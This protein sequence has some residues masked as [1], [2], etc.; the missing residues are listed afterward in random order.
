VD[1]NVSFKTSDGNVI[2]K[3]T[4]GQKYLPVTFAQKGE[5]A[6]IPTLALNLGA[7]WK[8]GTCYF[9]SGGGNPSGETETAAV[10]NPV[11]SSGG[12]SSEKSSGNTASA[13]NTSESTAKPCYV[14]N[15]QIVNRICHLNLK[16]VY[17]EY[18]ITTKMIQT[19]LNAEASSS[20]AVSSKA[21]SSDTGGQ[22]QKSGAPSGSSHK[23]SS[24]SDAK[25]STS[26]QGASIATKNANSSDINVPDA[27]GNNYDN[28]YGNGHP[29]PW[30]DPPQ[31]KSKN[32]GNVTCTIRCDTAVANWS[33]IRPSKRDNK[34]V[35][36]NG[37]IYSVHTLPI[38][39]NE[40]VYD[41][42]VSICKANNI[43]EEHTYTP[44]Y[45]AEYIKGINN[46]YEF[47]VGQLSGWMY[48]V[49]GWYPNYG[50]SRYVLQ[51]G[52]GVQWNYTCDLGR[53]LGQ[54][55][56]S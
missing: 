24:V 28:G 33:E 26:S 10:V 1:L 54:N 7:D 37:I 41:L 25:D 21:A 42:L 22:K 32:V 31:D 39:E 5:L 4:N 36:A 46:L 2:G 13:S 35:P 23:S 14:C 3:Q 27:N 15:T 49:N 45:K 16:R 40:T 48:C 50:C 29:A 55:W 47:D 56:V 19:S 34:V 18:F 43:Q 53:D 30:T 6:G 20:L 11:A 9:Y 51:N 38:Y 17:G 52:D 8:D 44:A 12:T